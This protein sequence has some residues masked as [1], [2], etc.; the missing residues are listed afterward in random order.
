MLLRFTPKQQ[1]NRDAIK[2]KGKQGRRDYKHREGL[3]KWLTVLGE[4]LKRLC[5]HIIWGSKI[6]FIESVFLESMRTVVKI[7]K[8]T[9][10]YGI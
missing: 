10:R 1:Q 4:L 2:N 8:K 3:L 7:P 5:G 9:G 6:V